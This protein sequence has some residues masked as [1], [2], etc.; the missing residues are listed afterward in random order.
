MR[1][2]QHGRV[3]VPGKVPQGG[4]QFQYPLCLILFDLEGK[5]GMTRK[6]IKFWV[7]KLIIN[8]AGELSFRG[9]QF[10]FLRMVAKKG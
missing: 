7:K 9:T 3:F 10:H 8:S 1:N 2:K 5:R 6:R 4:D